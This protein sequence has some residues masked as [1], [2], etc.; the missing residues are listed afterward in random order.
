VRP[1]TEINGGAVATELTQRLVRLL[2]NRER[3]ELER[4]GLGIFDRDLLFGD[5]AR[6][7]L[8]E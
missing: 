1:I 4:L 6:V 5:R 8:F 3:R 7:V 2:L